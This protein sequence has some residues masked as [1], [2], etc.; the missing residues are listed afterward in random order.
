[1]GEEKNMDV[2]PGTENEKKTENGKKKW[3][4]GGAAAVAVCAVVAGGVILSQPDPKEVVIGAFESIW[5]EEQTYPTEELFDVKE[6]FEQIETGDTEGNFVLKLDGSSDGSMDAYAGTGL[7]M[8]LRSDKT[9]K[10]SDMD[11]AVMYQG[12]DFL[13][14]QGYYGDE[15]LQ[16]AAPE[17]TE[18][19]LKLDLSDGLVDRLY[20]SPVIGPALKEAQD[21]EGLKEYLKDMETSLREQV[22]KAQTEPEETGFAGLWKRYKEGS[23]AQENFKAALLVKKGEKKPFTV[24][25]KEVSCRGY[26][27]TVSKDSMITF[28][29]E[30]EE[31]FLQDEQFKKEFLDQMEF[32]VTMTNL[33]GG[34]MESTPTAEQLQQQEYEEAKQNVDQ[35][36]NQLEQSLND[37]NMMVYVDKKGRLAACSGSTTLNPVQTGEQEDNTQSTETSADN[38]E[39]TTNEALAKEPSVLNFD[40]QLQGGSYLTQNMLATLSS[41]EGENTTQVIL[42]KKGTY[43]GNSLSG[44]ISAN[45]VSSGEKPMD[46]TIQVTDSY[47]KDDGSYELN[48]TGDFGE[49]TPLVISAKGTVDELEKGKTFHADI[50][51]LTFGAGSETFT[52]SGELG[53]KPLEGEIVPL[54]GEEF[55]MVSAAEEDWSNLMMEILFGALGMAGQ[56]QT[57]AQ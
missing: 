9:D 5:D 40:I 19:V 53:V 51:E 28:L 13:T 18:K 33:I 16:I 7:R 31:F 20:E 35:M 44:D 12:M 22:E 6:L 50:E 21:P 27:V 29:R 36:I 23:K 17:L 43:D 15:Q 2:V 46:W 48:M 41:T 55:D 30:S 4:I 49:D 42:D 54:Q 26:E 45:L 1:M 38:G 14:F 32:S 10:K 37:V 24:D 25:G 8:A 57:P 52:L 11:L 47:K 56:L 34:T 39:K 3:V